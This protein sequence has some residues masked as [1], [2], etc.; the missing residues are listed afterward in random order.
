[1][2]V[3]SKVRVLVCFLGG[4]NRLATGNSMTSEA[5]SFP[6]EKLAFEYAEARNFSSQVSRSIFEK[7]RTYIDSRI[8]L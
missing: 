7:P 5:R 2:V 1:V 3:S 8:Q 4:W 6:L